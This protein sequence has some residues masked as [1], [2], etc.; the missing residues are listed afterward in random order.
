MSEQHSL[1]VKVA[2]L[3]LYNGH[4]NQGMR[5]IRQILNEFRELHNLE[6]VYDEFD[7][8]RNNSVPDLSYDVFISTGGPGSPLKAKGW[9]GKKNILIG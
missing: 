1:P 8:R 6:L 3:D 5:C 7:V 2:I 9:N 4:A